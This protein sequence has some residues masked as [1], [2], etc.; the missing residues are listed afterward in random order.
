MMFGVAGDYRAA[1]IVQYS[2][3]VC[4]P[5][6]DALSYLI[7]EFV[8][9]LR[10]ALEDGGRMGTKDGLEDSELTA[11]V[12]LRG[13]LFKVQRDA[14]VLEPMN[15]ILA[16]GSGGEVAYGVLRASTDSPEERIKRA[17]EIS[18]EHTCYV[19]P[20]YFIA[21]EAN[22]WKIEEI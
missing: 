14:S 15:G 11:L 9:E 6:D 4:E 16:I 3:S 19:S 8:P 1:Q 21:K 13:K 5:G 20:P 22:D 2:L 17:L 12:G 18:G 7:R 10:K